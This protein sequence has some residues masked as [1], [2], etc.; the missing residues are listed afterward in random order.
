MDREEEQ[1]RMLEEVGWEP[2]EGEGGTIWRNPEDGNW[3][4]QDRA[5]QLLEGA[6]TRG[7]AIE[8]GA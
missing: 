6:R 7:A 4:E 1:R 8:G 3:Y 5:V 2:D